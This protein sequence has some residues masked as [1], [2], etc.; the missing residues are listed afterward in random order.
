MT[1]EA[2]KELDNI[3]K[4]LDELKNDIKGL[5][6]ALT[7]LGRQRVGDA[8]DKIGEKKDDLL[9][10]LSLAEIKQRLADLKDEGED[11]L[12]VVREQ[13][14]K[15]PA[16]TLLAAVGVGVLIGRLMGGSRR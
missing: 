8:A 7:D 15:Y 9:D 1:T 5:T 13:L 4:D 6:S 11:A 16:G 14:E 3:K 10:S 2:N 12:D